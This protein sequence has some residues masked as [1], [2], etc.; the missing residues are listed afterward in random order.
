MTSRRSFLMGSAAAVAVLALPE[1]T[2]AYA[3][4]GYIAAGAPFPPIM[5]VHSHLEEWLT[6]RLVE[7]LREAEQP[8][9]DE[10]L[11]G[12]GAGRPLGI[13]RIDHS[14]QPAQT[15]WNKVLHLPLPRE[16]V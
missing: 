13:L 10:L 6:R 3:E 14:V 8:R 11:Y 5:D 1:A 7:R 12:P 2:M 16:E 4:G 9:I 15:E